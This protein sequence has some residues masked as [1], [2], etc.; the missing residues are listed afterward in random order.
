MNARIAPCGLAATLLTVLSIS[1]KATAQVSLVQDINSRAHTEI[2]SGN[3]REL[4]QVGP[5]TYFVAETRAG[6]RIFRLSASATTPS[7]VPGFGPTTSVTAPSQLTAFGNRLAFSAWDR[8]TGEELWI[9]ENGTARLLH[10]IQ[11]GAIN[12]SPTHLTVHGGRLYFEAQDYANKRSQLW[13]TDGTPNGLRLL[14]SFGTP[15][16]IADLQSIGAALLFRGPYAATRSTL[17]V[18]DGTPTGTKA[19]IP[20]RGPLSAPREITRVGNRAFFAATDTATGTELW[21]SD[22]SAAGTRLVRDIRVGMSSSHP[23]GLTALGNRVFFVANDSA[24]GWELWESDGSVAGTKKH[25]LAPGQASSSPSQLAVSRGRLWFTAASAGN[26]REPWIADGVTAPRQVADL[27]PGHASSLPRQFVELGNG[28]AFVMRELTG[29]FRLMISL[30]TA[31]TTR[32]LSPISPT[33]RESQASMLAVGPILLFNGD[34]GDSVGS[35]L[36][37]TLF[38]PNTTSLLADLHRYGASETQSSDIR[39]FA[40][41]ASR[42]FFSAND[43]IH[44]REAWVSDGTSRGTQRLTDIRPGLGSSNAGGF[45][46]TANGIVFTASTDAHGSEL[47]VLRNNTPSLLADLSPGSRSSTPQNFIPMGGQLYFVAAGANFARSLYVTDGT[48][49]GTKIVAPVSPRSEIVRMHDA[50]YWLGGLPT[51]PTLMRSDGTRAGTR[52]IGALR[53]SI[54]AGLHPLRVVGN[55]LFVLASTNA[56]GTELWVSD[57]QSVSLVTELVPGSSDARPSDLTV[58]G[59][60]VFFTA[61]ISSS[62]RE[63][64]RSDGSK[65]G[66]F[67]LHRTGFN[68]APSPLLAVGEECW[69]PA[70]NGSAW[71]TWKSDGSPQGTRR[72]TATFGALQKRVGDDVLVRVFHSNRFE[73]VYHYYTIDRHSGAQTQLRA[74]NNAPIQ[75]NRNNS[76]PQNVALVHGRCFMAVRSDEKG[77]EPH[78][79]LPGATAQPIGKSC[80]GTGR[81][82]RIDARDPRIGTTWTLEGRGFAPNRAS[83]TFLG[84]PRSRPLLLAGGC[85]LHVDLATYL[86]IGASQ[87][88]TWTLR[89]NLPNDA[90]LLGSTFA[91]QSLQ[92]ANDRLLGFDLSAALHATLGR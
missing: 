25:D 50:L 56:T 16:G 21:V 52:A 69:F 41:V 88:A 53:H 24:S 44:G 54:S 30:G 46:E 75:S 22:G 48:A 72:V 1:T 47:W 89:A 43:G 37:R 81:N 83:I 5:D 77:E 80:A 4:T 58:A 68:Q 2:L 10:D 62:A 35:E 90:R 3:P 67:R 11:Q 60:L 19:L 13:S 32:V 70:W 87:S 78:V 23:A 64:W 17:F 12:A 39:S 61:G 63:L 7:V 33:P 34:A 92:V 14:A 85:D 15:N 66:T 29:K 27:I 40:P 49:A 38:T 57:G 6:T 31:A 86:P 76:N 79:W 74:A 9:V 8:A 20:A 84:A 36:Y 42:V 59:D 28:T 65:S 45:T 18:S 91:V 55:R 73:V 71:E 26:G 51:S 82:P